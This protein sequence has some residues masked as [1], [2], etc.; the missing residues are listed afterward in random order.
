[1]LANSIFNID[2][3]EAGNGEAALEHCDNGEFDVVFLDSNMPG[4]PGTQTLERLL[5]R[6]PG[7][8]VIMISGERN[9]ER[10]KWALDRG[11]FTFLTSRSTPPISI[12]SC[13]RCSGC[14]AR[15]S[16]VSSR[17]ALHAP[18]PTRSGK[19]RGPL[20]YV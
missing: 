9:E 14:A 2:V 10:R 5:E 3:T 4:L 8:K 13:T 15:C 1:V 18:R 11:A 19:P 12:A 16:P 6:D 17:C 20:R 7:V